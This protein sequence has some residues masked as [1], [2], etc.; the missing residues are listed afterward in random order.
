MQMKQNTRCLLILCSCNPRVVELQK[1]K[2]AYWRLIANTQCRNITG[3]PQKMLKPYSR[4]RFH[5]MKREKQRERK[6][7]RRSEKEAKRLWWSTT[8][9]MKARRN[10]EREGQKKEKREVSLSRAD[11]ACARSG[12][13]GPINIVEMRQI[14]LKLSHVARQKGTG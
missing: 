2:R 9:R 11:V 13:T 14:N 10:W 7:E 1:L 12:R 8:E 5:R 3:L 6:R 4:G